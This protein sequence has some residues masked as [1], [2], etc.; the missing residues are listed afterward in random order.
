[1]NGERGMRIL[2]LLL[3][4]V[5]GLSAFVFPAEAQTVHSGGEKIL[6]F[7]IH[8]DDPRSSLRAFT[9]S[10]YS[11][12]ADQIAG[13]FVPG[14]MAVPIEAQPEGSPH[15]VS[16]DPTSASLFSAPLQSGTVGLL[17]HSHLAGAHFSQLELNQTIVLIHG[18]GRLTLYQ[19]EGLEAYQALEP[20]NPYSTFRSLE[21]GSLWNSLELYDHIYAPGGRLVLQTCFEQDGQPNWGRLFVIAAPFDRQSTRIM[22]AGLPAKMK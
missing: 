6:A 11:G 12:Q 18:D 4:G 21:N 3:I 20:H 17:A 1:M 19:V 22:N 2:L 10:L 15:Y 7:T 8:W 5:N 14:L 16:Q 13:V 9:H